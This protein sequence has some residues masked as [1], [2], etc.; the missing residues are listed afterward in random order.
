MSTIES[1]KSELVEIEEVFF[2][3]CTQQKLLK[4]IDI[5]TQVTKE[6]SIAELP[7]ESRIEL[8]KRLTKEYLMTVDVSFGR[9]YH[10]QEICD[11]LRKLVGVMDNYRESYR[12]DSIP[13]LDKMIDILESGIPE[14]PVHLDPPQRKI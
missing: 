13:Y 8:T 3:I 10:R 6:M 5:A 14:S 7:S 9:S 4:V 2:I 1:D 11:T 12:V